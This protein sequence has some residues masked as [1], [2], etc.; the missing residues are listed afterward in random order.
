MFP[1]PAPSR[2]MN[3]L[4]ADTTNLSLNS[5]ENRYILNNSDE[6]STTRFSTFM[7]RV[8]HGNHPLTFLSYAATIS[9]NEGYPHDTY[10]PQ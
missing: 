6:I 2:C 8:R 3:F 10:G 7:K 9:M 1:M 5:T 4:L